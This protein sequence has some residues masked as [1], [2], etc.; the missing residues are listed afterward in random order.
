M[1]GEWSDKAVGRLG[2]MWGPLL[3]LINR[4]VPQSNVT[5]PNKSNVVIVTVFGKFYEE[6]DTTDTV[7]E[8]KISATVSPPDRDFSE[9]SENGLCP[10]RL[11]G[12][13]CYHHLF[14]SRSAGFLCEFTA[15]MTS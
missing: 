13:T 12:G 10:A 1:V 7:D 4:N 8:K 15:E 6:K 3:N 9:L 11:M 5:E 2:G 14:R